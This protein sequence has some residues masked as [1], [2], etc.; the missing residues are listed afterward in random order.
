MPGT[1]P[2]AEVVLVGDVR[3]P[4]LGILV[5]TSTKRAAPDGGGLLAA[6]GGGALAAGLAEVR[7]LGGTMPGTMPGAE[8]VLV[9]DVLARLPAGEAPSGAILQYM[10][11]ACR[12]HIRRRESV[13][14][15]SHVLRRSPCSAPCLPRH[16][17]MQAGRLL[18][19]LPTSMASQHGECLPT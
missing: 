14:V 9:G 13:A 19:C 15:H 2:G 7:D 18:S 5:G 10:P 6:L 8:V 3:G 12:A 16:A 11:V 17:C 1:M 4:G